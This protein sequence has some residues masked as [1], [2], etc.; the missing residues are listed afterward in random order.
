MSTCY[1]VLGGY[2][3]YEGSVEFEVLK[4]FHD[5]DRAKEFVKDTK[6]VSIKNAELRRKFNEVT[7]SHRPS[8]KQFDW[9]HISYPVKPTANLV[10]LKWCD[11]KDRELF[12]KAYKKYEV[13]LKESG[14]AQLLSEYKK[15][16][17]IIDA[18]INKII[19]D[20]REENKKNEEEFQQ[21]KREKALEL[22]DGLYDEKGINNLR[23]L[24]NNYYFKIKESE[25]E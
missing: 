10:K 21:F 1:V 8:Q 3:W 15:E 23:V 5:K 18:N 19:D 22:S 12:A 25:I 16:C 2:D 9:Y 11:Y 24:G 6:S 13:D 7:E 17:A 20:I 14:Y 4:V